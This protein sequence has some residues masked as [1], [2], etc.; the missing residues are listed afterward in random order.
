MLFNLEKKYNSLTC[1][2]QINGNS[3]P[4][5]ISIKGIK[6][7]PGRRGW[8]FIYTLNITCVVMIPA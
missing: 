5:G 2:L 3:G 8:Y 7:K 4:Q 6:G 1:T